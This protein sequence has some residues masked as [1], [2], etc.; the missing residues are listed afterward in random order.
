M[1]NQIN[2]PENTTQNL[3]PIADVPV[4]QPTPQKPDKHMIIIVAATAIIIVLIII[5]IG[6]TRE[7][8]T[9]PQITATATPT[10]GIQPTNV[11]N[12]TLSLV[13]TQSAFLE[14]D[15]LVASLSASINSTTT[16]DVSLTPPV[17]ELSLG[18]Q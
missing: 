7:I 13:A 2:Q 9:S 5:I 1:D 15:Q 16:S 18:L 17:V 10:F 3:P 12:R 8:K 11:P 14:L 4:T 6:I